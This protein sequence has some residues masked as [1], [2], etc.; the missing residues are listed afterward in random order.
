MNKA[1]TL[2]ITG[3][4]ASLLALSFIAWGLQHRSSKAA[5]PTV[6]SADTIVKKQVYDPVLL[7][8]YERIYKKYDTLK[9]A[10]TMAGSI[11]INDPADTASNMKKV[12]FFFC[13]RGDGFYYKLGTTETINA[14]GVYLFID[15]LAQTIMVSG[16]KQIAYDQ[17]P[18]AITGLG[19]FLSIGEYALSGKLTGSEQT[20]SLINE[21]NGSCKQF[22]LSYDTVTM[23]VNRIYARLTNIQAPL[24]E[25]R[26]EVVDINITQW[27]DKAE[28]NKYIVI[29][30]ILQ[31][32][33]NGWTGTNKYKDYQVV[34][35]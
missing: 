10:Y 15:N 3:L 5:K 35:R 8:K 16:Q 14:K 33:K 34:N 32:D 27:T 11:D 31:K 24:T 7:G 12:G 29:G 30:N 26:D 22:S 25:A 2:K 18:D 20:L 6:K 19:K 28:L 13:K 17:Q 1:T 23:E 21:H 9:T 4:S